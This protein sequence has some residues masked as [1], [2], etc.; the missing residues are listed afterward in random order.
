MNH[1]VE[2]HF[3]NPP[4]Q[5]CHLPKEAAAI[6]INNELIT[7]DPTKALRCRLGKVQAREFL[8]SEKGW[9]P[10]QFDEV[11]WDSI[12]KVLST[13]PVMFRLWLTS[14]QCSNFCA[15]GKN[16]ACNAQAND[17]QCPSCW[18]SQANHLCI[19]P[20]EQCTQLF[21]DNICELEHW[22]ESHNS[23]SLELAY[24]MIKDLQG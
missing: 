18:W 9:S 4:P 6:F 3:E 11:A 22:M 24:W 8:T 17:D 5:M 16:M 20:S 12:H 23:T 2:S 21:L 19:C 1:A 10:Q 13:K 7:L 15:T 14:K